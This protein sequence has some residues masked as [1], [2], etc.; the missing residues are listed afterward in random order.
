[1][2]GVGMAGYVESFYES[3]CGHISMA[4]LGVRCNLSLV[5]WLA[6]KSSYGDCHI[7]GVVEFCVFV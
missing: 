2:Y 3:R 1:M 4:L 5:A 7:L 6:K